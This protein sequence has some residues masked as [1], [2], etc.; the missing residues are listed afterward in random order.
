MLYKPGYVAWVSL[1]HHRAR[2]NRMSDIICEE[3][4]ASLDGI[5]TSLAS[6]ITITASDKL[7]AIPE[8]CIQ[9]SVTSSMPGSVTSSIPNSM[10]P[11]LGEPLTSPCTP[12]LA[13][14]SSEQNVMSPTCYSDT[15][16]LAP[17]DVSVE[18]GYEML[19]M[20]IE[21]PTSCTMD[22]WI[23]EREVV[24]YTVDFSF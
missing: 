7:M 24:K 12:D 11:S 3:V 8:D 19:V 21:T 10:T 4:V 16:E 23:R 5:M 9:D 14:T 22:A 2:V 20:T 13:M 18:H 17:G 15:G 1:Q 6:E